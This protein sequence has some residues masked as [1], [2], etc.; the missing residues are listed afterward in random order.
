MKQLLLLLCLLGSLFSA[1]QKDSLPPT[2]KTYKLVLHSSNGNT[3]DYFVRGA[4]DS[5]LY[6]STTPILLGA[7]AS[8][9][10]S[11]V[12]Y[13]NI[14]SVFV[15]RKGQAGR[16][17]L[18]FGIVG[19]GLGAI[20]GFANGDDAPGGWFRIT[21]GEKALAGGISGGLVGTVIGLVAG[22]LSGRQFMIESQHTNFLRL[23]SFLDKT[24]GPRP[25]Q[26]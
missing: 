9:G 1:G 11:R 2:G 24:A 3:G 13:T 18:V 21:A 26:Y 6:V 15:A 22:A 10:E 14:R 4:D 8:A 25:I 17:A 12:P 20:V 5:A 23:K 16:N 7:P 19:L